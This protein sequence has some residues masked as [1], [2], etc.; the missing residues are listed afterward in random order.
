M[1]VNTQI[2]WSSHD[3]YLAPFTVPMFLDPLPSAFGLLAAV[4]LALGLLAG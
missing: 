2:T 3:H 1:P 4:T